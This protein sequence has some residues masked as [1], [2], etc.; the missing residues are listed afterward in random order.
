MFNWPEKILAAIVE[1]GRCATVT[2]TDIR[3]S[4][5]RE[6]GS[7]LWISASF[8]D[9]SIGG[10]YLEHECQRLARAKLKQASLSPQRQ[11]FALGSQCG[12]C[13][14]GVVHVLIDVLT[15][16]DLPAL[17]ALITARQESRDAWLL[18]GM[19]GEHVVI[20]QSGSLWP[21]ASPIAS[22]I[23][24]DQTAIG[25]QT[26]TEQP[27]VDWFIER[28][29][30]APL[31]VA[32]FGAGHVGSACAQVFSTLNANITVIDNRP[33]QLLKPWPTNVSETYVANPIDF[34]PHIPKNSFAL[35]MTHDHAIDL[36]LCHRLL[37]Q[38]SDVFCGLIGSRPKRRR[39]EKR[40][41]ALGHNDQDLAR[42]TCPIGIDGIKGKQPGNIAIAV[43]AQV[44]QL[45]QESIEQKSDDAVVR[46]VR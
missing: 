2:V 22:T 18:T 11:R 5:P 27:S 3:G 4:A 12:Q 17:Q 21:A 16:A 7:K 43:A 45:S 44:L 20:D 19:N 24:A 34:V 25:W 15:K 6:V 9:G 38:R 31:Q 8:E 23:A 1:D 36:E 28:I 26:F 37:E 41:K 39:F 29:A 33:E 10:G 46:A 32:I 35:I 42:L 13:C 40:L 30:P 14:G